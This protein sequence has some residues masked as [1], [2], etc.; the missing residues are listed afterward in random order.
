MMQLVIVT[1][2]LPS[3]HTTARHTFH[4]QTIAVHANQQFWQVLVLKLP[5]LLLLWL[6]SKACQAS[7]SA[8]V[9]FKWLHLPLT[10]RQPAV[11][12]QTTG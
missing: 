10:S 8:R 9:V 6:V 3:T 1:E 4:H 12:H 7:M 5:R 11:I 2:F